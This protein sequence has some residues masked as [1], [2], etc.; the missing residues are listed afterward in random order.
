VA[1]E[2][3]VAHDRSVKLP[4]SIK[5]AYGIGQAAEGIKGRSFGLFALFYYTA[6]LGLPG[7]L[8]GFALAVAMCVDAVTDPLIGSL[9]D[10]WRSRLGRRHPFMYASAVPL[11]ITFVGLFMPPAFVQ[12]D[13]TLLFL[14]L[15]TFAVLVRVSMTFYFVPHQA[16]G[17]ELTDNYAE[18]SSIVAIRMLFAAFG[19]TMVYV[20]GFQVF[21]HSTPEFP[22]GQLNAA[23]YPPFAMLFAL[24][25]AA[26]ILISA[27]GT[28]KEIG[29]LHQAVDSGETFGLG[30]LAREIGGAF[31]NRS[32]RVLF[33]SGVV[34][35]AAEGLHGVLTLHITTYFWELSPNQVMWV[36]LSGMAG[37]LLGLPLVRPLLF[38]FDKKQ[39]LM[40]GVL[41][42]VIFQAT[43]ALA[44]LAGLMPQNGDPLLLPILITA[45]VLGAIGVVQAAICVGSM[46][47]DVADEHEYESGRRQ[48]GVFFGGVAFAAKGS[49]AIGQFVAGLGLDLINFPSRARPGELDPETVW[50]LGVLYGPG[51][52]VFGALAVLI[53]SGYQL[54]RERHHLILRELSTR[55]NDPPAAAS[56]VVAQP[57]G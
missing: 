29:R 47:A 22:N 3:A 23:A 42:F 38:R 9:S 7:T 2:A 37:L 48:E 41:F 13:P 35:Y 19:G 30:M 1:G 49:L 15:T 55:R 16:Q 28:Q 18:R 10:N 12:Q 14:W 20:I 36:T 52:I 26:A 5:L 32:F 33:I 8:A 11:G 50:N 17:A 45:A 31:A 43:P 46:M 4:I 44:R 57:A 56:A 53:L 24:L 21:F 6:V 34:F 25:M 27:F 54:T 39:I 51:V 40:G